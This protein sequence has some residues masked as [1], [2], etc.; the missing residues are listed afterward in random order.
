MNAT[1]SRISVLTLFAILPTAAVADPGF[2]TAPGA[3]AINA[4]EAKALYDR[5][6]RFIDV[7]ME[8]SRDTQGHIPRSLQLGTKFFSDEPLRKFARRDDE[9]VFYCT[10]E[11]CANTYYAAV[12][13]SEWGYRKLYQLRDGFEGWKS[14]GLPVEK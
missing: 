14:R 3:T 9:L 12:A 5:G 4:N 13:A 7:R 8:G 6:A 11:D 2:R 1:V 10:N